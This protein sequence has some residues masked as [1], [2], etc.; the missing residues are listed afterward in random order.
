MPDVQTQTLPLLPLTT[1]VVLPQMVVTL[2]LETDEAK[3]AADAATS[4]DGTLLLVPRTAM[5]F[6]RVGTVA[7]VDRAGNLPNGTPALILRGL[8]RASLGAAVAGTGS[9]LWVEVEPVDEPAPS[10]QAVALAGELRATLAAIAETW[11]ARR[12]AAIVEGIT[13]P[14]A[15][16]DTAGSWPDLELE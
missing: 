9:A 16:A 4:G 1:G 12:L 6:A 11:G 2:A 7:K 15:L 10:E 8:H 3:A 13:D 5:G 14:S